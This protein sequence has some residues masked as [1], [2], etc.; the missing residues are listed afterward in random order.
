[1]ENNLETEHKDCSTCDVDIRPKA[2]LEEPV[3]NILVVGDQQWINKHQKLIKILEKTYTIEY[4]TEINDA[5]ERLWHN[6]YDILL[7]EHQFVKKYTIDLTKLAYARSKPSVI[8]C[9][10]GLTSMY[11]NLWKKFSKLTKTC[12]TMKKLM[13]PIQQNRDDLVHFINRIALLSHKG[14]N[15]TQQINIE[16]K[17]YFQK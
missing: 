15:L 14:M 10:N 4:K 12:K 7:I 8:L 2:G 13:Y 16:I 17:E 3:L 9:Q 11:Y 6:S 1:M 5:L